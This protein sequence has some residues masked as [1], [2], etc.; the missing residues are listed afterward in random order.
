[1]ESSAGTGG[2]GT[3]ANGTAA[4]QNVTSQKDE[5]YWL[6]LTILLVAA[7]VVT[8]LV[9]TLYCCLRHHDEIQRGQ[10][11]SYEGSSLRPG[12]GDDVEKA[13]AS[14]GE[15]AVGTASRGAQLKTQNTDYDEEAP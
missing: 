11:A 14:A 9:L 13:G 12:S 5:A 10:Q 2:S 7:A 6:G 1:M 8:A 3:S 4:D 15:A